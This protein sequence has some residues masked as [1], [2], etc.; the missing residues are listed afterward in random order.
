VGKKGDTHSV[1]PNSSLDPPAVHP[2]ANGDFEIAPRILEQCSEVVE[3]DRKK[4][5]GRN[6]ECYPVTS[7]PRLCRRIT[8]FRFGHLRGGNKQRERCM[9]VAARGVDERKRTEYD[10]VV[11]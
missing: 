11:G 9:C 4:R 1:L 5:I 7:A 10:E 8:I 2:R 6:I 3:L